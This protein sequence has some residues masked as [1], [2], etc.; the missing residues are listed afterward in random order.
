MLT[1]DR[2]PTRLSSVLSQVGSKLNLRQRVIA[3]ATIF[4]RRFYLKNAYCETDPYIVIAACLYVAAKAEEQ[5]V[6]IKTVVSEARAVFGAYGV[7]H[8]PTDNAK[9]AEMEF[10]LVDDLECDLVVFHPYRTLMALVNDVQPKD[11]RGMDREAGEVGT[12]IDD[13]R[14][15]W[16]TG[17]GRLNLNTSAIQNAW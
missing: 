3:T 7:K 2:S 6:H 9:L 8:F 12:G 16:G 10:Y 1:S 5:P 15:F 4:F 14:R 17:E 13:G 11:Q